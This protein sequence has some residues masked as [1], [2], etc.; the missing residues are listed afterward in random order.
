MD[1][2]LDKVSYEAN[3]LEEISFQRG[4]KST[5]L[6]LPLKIN[7]NSVLKFSGDGAVMNMLLY[8]CATAPAM[9][10]PSAADFPLPLAAVRATVLRR[11]FSAIASVKTRRA[12][13]WSMVLARF[14]SDPMGCT[15]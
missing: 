11:V 14:T 4:E 8:P 7:W 5:A 13:A 6:T 15:M 12:L 1:Y 9:A 10:I 2:S 3:I